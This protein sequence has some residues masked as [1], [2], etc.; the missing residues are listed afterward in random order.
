MGLA[1]LVGYLLGGWLD[2]RLG[3]APYLTW[4]MVGIGIATGFRALARVARA[5]RRAAD[6]EQ[7]EEQALADKTGRPPAQASTQTGARTREKKV[8]DPHDERGERGEPGDAP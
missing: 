8:I 3:T 2:R 7:A 6:R 1:L 4:V 5:Y